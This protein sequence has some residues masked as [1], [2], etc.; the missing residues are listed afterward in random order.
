MTGEFLKEIVLNSKEMILRALN[1]IENAAI[2]TNDHE[3]IEPLEELVARKEEL[4]NTIDTFIDFAE[5]M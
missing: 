5:D 4:K 3:F 2:A 1:D